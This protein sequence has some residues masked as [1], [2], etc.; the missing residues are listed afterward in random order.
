MQKIV[1]V[2]MLPTEKGSHIVKYSPP[3]KG[4]KGLEY[5]DR[6][7]YAL[8][9]MEL[10]FTSDEE[11]KEEDW[12]MHSGEMIFRADPKFDEGNNP[13]NSNPRVTDHN[14]KIVAT[15]NPELWHHGDMMICLKTPKI[16]LSF[17][18]EYVE[19][20]GNIKKVKLEYID[21]G[22]EVDMGGVGGEDIGWMPKIELKLDSQGCVI[23]SPIEEKIDWEQVFEN[24][25][26]MHLQ[27]F[28][29]YYKHL[30]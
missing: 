14:K 22:Y 10:Y 2:H 3:A 11:I 24:A 25:Q 6:I 27:E 23:V 28:I 5:F 21:N 16:P 15:T 19:K 12:Y 29:N 26:S 13:N 30:K 7:A 17:V 8:I 18:K 20:Q 1:Q 4:Q 9:N